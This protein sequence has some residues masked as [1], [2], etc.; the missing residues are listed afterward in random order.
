MIDDLC[1]YLLEHARREELILVSPPRIVFHTDE[2]LALG[3]FGIQAQ[4]VHP[5]GQ[6]EKT[7]RPAAAEPRR[8]EVMAKR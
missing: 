6:S 2:Q 5:A 1:A 3:E 4:S 8:P 7:H